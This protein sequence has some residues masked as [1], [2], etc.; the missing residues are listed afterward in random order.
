MDKY[1]ENTTNPA[2][3]NDSSGYIDGGG[4]ELG[5]QMDFGN[6]FSNQFGN[7]RLFYEST[8]GPTQ[9]YTAT[10]FG[11]RFVLKCLKDQYRKEPIYNLWLAKEFE[12][13]ISLDHPNIRR[14][15]GL[16]AVPGL[17]QTIVLEYVDGRS[18]KSLIEAGNINSATARA[19]A[20]QIAD[21]LGYIHS[22]QVY[23]RDLKPANILVSCQSNA[24]KIIDFNYS[25][26]DEF[27]VLKNPAGS[28]RYMAPEQ[29]EAK[30]RPTA[31]ADIY[32]FGMVMCELAAAA[33]DGD[34]AEMASKCMEPHPQKRPQSVSSISVPKPQS[35]L[36]YAISAFLSSKTLTY[37]LLALCAAFITSIAIMLNP[38]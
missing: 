36:R 2:E 30:A 17:G 12:I 9:L 23:H 27:V 19:I 22:K 8:S 32:S 38:V 15:I 35:P 37:V 7:I 24:V 34:L 18:L 33:G 31:V 25:D 26:S 1:H 20:G 28:K 3:D 4:D 11:K 16:E 29:F 5:S 10:R 14:T 13:G 21:A 6:L